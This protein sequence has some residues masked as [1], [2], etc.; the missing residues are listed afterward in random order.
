MN[1]RE[2]VEIKVKRNILIVS[3]LD[4]LGYNKNEYTLS[5]IGLSSFQEIKIL[6]YY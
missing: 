5:H 6:F 4:L 1:L 2:E 3:N